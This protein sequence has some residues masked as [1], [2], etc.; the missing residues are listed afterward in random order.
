MDKLWIP[1]TVEFSG[2]LHATC[3][4]TPEIDPPTA[5]VKLRL[6]VEHFIGAEI[7]AGLHSRPLQ[8]VYCRGIASLSSRNLVL[9]L[10]S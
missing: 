7:N 8:T 5:P 10:K 1:L 9:D 6:T 4:L 2:Y 3:M